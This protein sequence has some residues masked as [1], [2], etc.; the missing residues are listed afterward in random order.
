[1]VRVIGYDEN[2]WTDGVNK[3]KESEK[4]YNQLINLASDM[5][6]K[7]DKE[8]KLTFINPSVI[9]H[10]GYSNDELINN[11]SF[12]YVHPEDLDNVRSTFKKIL[13]NKKL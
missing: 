11:M 3:L 4:K 2:G 6:A 5:I 13:N 8:G 10:L 12:E 7:V 1:M 9:N